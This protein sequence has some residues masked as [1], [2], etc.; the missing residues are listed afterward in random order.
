MVFCFHESSSETYRP[1]TD[2]DERLAQTDTLLRSFA[3]DRF[4]GKVGFTPLPHHHHPQMLPLKRQS[5]R[6]PC[7]AARVSAII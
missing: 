4:H 2:C 7:T 6:L 5:T 3:F 1:A